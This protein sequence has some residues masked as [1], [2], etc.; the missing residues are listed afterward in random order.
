MKPEDIPSIN[1]IMII[2]LYEIASSR[3]SLLFSNPYL[4]PKN[5]ATPIIA[6]TKYCILLWSIYLI[7]G[8]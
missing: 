3:V 2:E 5:T 1:E 4:A 6:H 8:Y 7:T